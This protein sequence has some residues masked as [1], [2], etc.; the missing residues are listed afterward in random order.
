MHSP[1][2]VANDCTES[3]TQDTHLRPRRSTSARD[4]SH[5]SLDHFL[6]YCYY[7]TPKLQ[8]RQ[9]TTQRQSSAIARL[10]PLQGTHTA[11]IQYVSHSVPL[12][13]R[14][15]TTHSHVHDTGTMCVQHCVRHCRSWTRRDSRSY[16]TLRRRRVDAAMHDLHCGWA[17]R[18][19]TSRDRGPGLALPAACWPI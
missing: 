7:H 10:V 16:S 9:S 17:V 15:V 14:G 3:A 12:G 18:T 13:R 1:C 6:D 4:R 19:P 5:W 11:V 8:L 2:P